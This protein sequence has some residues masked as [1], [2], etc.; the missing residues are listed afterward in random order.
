MW[1]GVTGRAAA[2]GSAAPAATSGATAIPAPVAT[3][4]PGTPGTGFARCHTSQLAAAF[5]GLNAAMGGQRGMT[6]ILTNRSSRTCYVYGY[7][8]LGFLGSGLNP[9]PTHLTRDNVPYTRVT[10][11]PGGNAQAMVTWRVYPDASAPLEYP[12]RVEITP[13]DEYTHLIGAWPAEPVR[14]GDVSTLPLSAA[15]VAEAL[16]RLMH[17]EV[18]GQR[19]QLCRI[20]HSGTFW[21]ACSSV[22][23]G[24]F[25]P[26][27]SRINPVKE[28][29]ACLPASPAAPLAMAVIVAATS[30][31]ENESVMWPGPR[32]L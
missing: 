27:A 8:G 20:R 6:L 23:R 4:Q 17:G 21:I 18:F 26:S 31:P 5:T 16:P 14:G 28:V 10:L 11:R 2:T 15:A 22:F 30:V 7:E 24:G 19:T 9:L 12:Q 32:G 3:T 13:P 29:Q 1:S 25:R